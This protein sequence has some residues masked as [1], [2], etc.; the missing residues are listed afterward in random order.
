MACFVIRTFTINNVIA[1]R[2]PSPLQPGKR[3]SDDVAPQFGCLT[4]RFFP[5]QLEHRWTTP[6]ALT[7]AA[8]DDAQSSIYIA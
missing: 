5:F 2:N 3:G 7:F 8:P 4:G 1:R 6:A